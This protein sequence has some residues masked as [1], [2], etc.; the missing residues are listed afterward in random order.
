MSVQGF[1]SIKELLYS[2][3]H[4]SDEPLYLAE[5]SSRSILA[6]SCQLMKRAFWDY[7]IAGSLNKHN[8]A[9]HFQTRLSRHCVRVQV[10]CTL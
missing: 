8:K 5:V 9:V 7:V 10:P 2:R 6:L 3:A 1:L 4:L